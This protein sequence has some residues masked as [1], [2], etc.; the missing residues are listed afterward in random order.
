MTEFSAEEVRVLGVLMEN[1]LQ[2]QFKFLTFGS[3][4][5][6]FDFIPMSILILLGIVVLTGYNNHILK[7]KFEIKK[8]IS[9]I[10]WMFFFG[11][12][13]LLTGTA[14]LPEQLIVFTVPVGILLSLSFTK[15]TP[16]F[17]GLYHILLLFIVMLMHYLTLLGVI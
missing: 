3:G 15:M 5:K 6:F 8:K 12:L 7:K 11:L 9:L 16:P 2:N 17:D 4:I 1:H 13:F 10:Y 14:A